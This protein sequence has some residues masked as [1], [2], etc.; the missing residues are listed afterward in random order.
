CKNNR[1]A[2]VVEDLIKK[3]EK[4]DY[5]TGPF[6]KPPFDTYR[7][8]PIGVAYEDPGVIIDSQLMMVRLPEDER[9]RVLEI[10]HS[11]LNEKRCTKHEL[12]SIIAYLGHASRVSPAQ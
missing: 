12:L 2:R 6:V 5:T 10:V 1:S 4:Q 11:Y 3:D 7:I 8:S 9:V